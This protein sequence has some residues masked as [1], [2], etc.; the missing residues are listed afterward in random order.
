M[1]FIGWVPMTRYE[2]FMGAM[3]MGNNLID[4]LNVKYVV[5]GKRDVKGKLG[6]RL[7]KYDLV[8]DDDVKI[9]RNSK[10][11]PRAFP[12]HRADIVED[13]R[14][15]LRMLASPRFNPAKSILLEEPFPGKLSVNPKPET[16]SHVVIT[17]YENN[18][19]KIDAD[20]SDDGFV[21]VSEKFYPGWKAYLDGGE[22]KIYPANYTLRGVYVPRGKH[23][24][25]LTYEPDSS[26]VGITIT[27]ISFLVVTGILVYHGTVLRRQR[28]GVLSRT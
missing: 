20:M 17:S 5:V 15:I 28:S 21:V 14:M 10:V 26:K 27:L 2:D 25:V 24:V 1:I 18:K 22:T 13:K 12:V 9:L 16:G 7:G 23:E 11:L 8:V 19:I 4:L 6:D 3:G